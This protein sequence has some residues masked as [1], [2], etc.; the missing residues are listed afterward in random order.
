M[1]FYAGPAPSPLT[2]QAPAERI[3]SAPASPRLECGGRLPLTGQQPDE[4][5]ASCGTESFFGA[6]GI[7]SG[8]EKPGLYVDGTYLAGEQ[9]QFLQILGSTTNILL[10]LPYRA[11][12][13]VVLMTGHGSRAHS[14]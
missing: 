12:S 2:L 6:F 7:A 4:I 11:S 10:N 14:R 13:A 5:V 9:S 1:V 8:L 3:T